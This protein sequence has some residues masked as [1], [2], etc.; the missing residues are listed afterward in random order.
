MK[1]PISLRRKILLG[2][3]GYTLVLSTAV[4]LHGVIV[5]ESA[6]QL[7]WSSLLEV[8]LDH[9][10]ERQQDNPDAR[11]VDTQSLKL[12][13]ATSPQGLPPALRGLEPGVHDEIKIEGRESVAL[14]R[15]VD[16]RPIAIAL[17]ITDMKKHEI[18]TALL[19]LGSTLVMIVLLG[20]VIGWG[21]NRLVRPLTRMALDIGSLRP[22]EAGARI[23]I[24]SDA[25]HELVVIAGAL[26][27][28]L[29]RNQQFV[30]RERAFIDTASHELRTPVAV[31]TGATELALG[32]SDLPPPA[33]RQMVRI[34]RT[35]RDVE[36][37]ISL[38]LALAKDP[39]RLTRI[40]DRVALDQIL[41]E[42]VEDHRYLTNGKD[43]AIDIVAL[44]A[45]EIVAPVQIVQ[46]AIGNLLRNAIENSDQG[47]IE[48]RLLAD[49]TVVID[50]PGHGMSPE[51][52][53]AIYARMARGDDFTF[54][55]GGIGLAL[56]ARLCEHLGWHLEIEPGRQHGT[57]TTLAFHRAES[58][59]AGDFVATS[60]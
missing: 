13:D 40:S 30:E 58:E 12:F 20:L 1:T 22:D 39:A 53:S 59:S 49:T 38:L 41:P 35:A 47:R 56:I 29:Q 25:A 16:G 21:V 34:Q 11:W 10:T 23:P 52:I 5:N 45:C 46:A 6:E 26:N 3:F 4:L 24:A 42:I 55:K 36:Q 57:R 7:V 54:G 33:R 19:V 14:I 44:A 8:E 51:D 48:I 43:L 60:S 27:D 32:Q 15:I 9:F 31:I 18:D 2:L 17:D 50:D 28:Y 37:L